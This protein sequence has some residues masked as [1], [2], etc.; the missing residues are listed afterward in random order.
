MLDTATHT[1]FYDRPA[2]NERTQLTA[3]SHAYAAYGLKAPTRALDIKNTVEAGAK[4]V[5]AVS[6]ALARDA[7]LS[8]EAPDT[9]YADA[10]D[11]IRDAIAREAL[12]KAFGQNYESNLR[13]ALPTL[14]AE[15]ADDLEKHVAKTVKSFVTAAKRLP[16][17]AAALDAEANLAANTGDSLYTVRADLTRLGTVAGMY[18]AIIND[19]V[20]TS[21][22]L[23]AII[24]IVEFPRATVELVEATYAAEKTTLNEDELAGTRTIRQIETDLHYQ[25]I[26]VVL[27]AIA[28]GNYDGAR[29]EFGNVDTVRERR[30]NLTRAFSR[31]RA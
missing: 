28:Q 11:Q 20:I 24:P 22:G 25:G 16:E 31:T 9:W 3:I 18:P 26:D 13:P 23:K 8:D 10:L 5:H 19:S 29:I 7:F 21:P 15:A 1:K 6:D 17:G 14:L 12:A 2:T 27:I 30:N 4:S